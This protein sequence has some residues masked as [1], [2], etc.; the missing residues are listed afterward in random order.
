MIP[1]LGLLG[2]ALCLQVPAPGADAD[3]SEALRSEYRGLLAQESS[4]LDALAERLKGEGQTE[5]AAEVRAQIEPPPPSEG[6]QRFQPLPEV[7][8][9]SGRGLA[10]V[11]S[12]PQAAEARSLRSGTAKALFDLARRAAED[13]QYALAGDCLRGVIAREPDHP[14]ARRLLGYVRTQ[15][16]WATPH[17]VQMLKQG[18]VLH[19]DFG[20]VSADW[21]PHLNRGELPGLVI[22]GRVREWLPAEEANARRSSW[23]PPWQISTAPHFEIQTNVPL[24]EGV[25]FG[26]RLEALY[27]LFFALFAD[28]IGR[29]NLPLARRFDGASPEATRPIK[30]HQVWYFASKEEY[31]AF[32]R[33]VLHRDEHLSL[34]YYMPSREAA[35]LRRPPRSY[36]YRDLQHPGDVMAT[37]FHEAS[38]QLLF[39]SAGPSTFESNAGNYWVWE[40]LGTYFEAVAPQ[41]DGT[42]SYGS[43]E[44]TEFVRKR[45]G[46]LGRESILPVRSLVALSKARFH[47]QP[48][49]YRNY[50]EALALTIFL[51]HYD[52]GRYRKGFLDYVE[53]A[54]HGRL[55]P[56]SSRSLK[57]RLNISSY[58]ELDRQFLDFL[59]RGMKPA[60]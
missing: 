23:N 11:P 22:G 1:A 28:V 18:R 3:R 24:A 20:W 17:A 34:G 48:D 16:G 44:G 52:G 6:P 43:L 26:R 7:I 56:G 41:P 15:D 30:K 51:M 25:A 37:L 40:G 57:S 31:V 54:Y 60:T 19:P 55:R 35:P 12:A 2:L 53:D 50:A 27:D 39:E 38:H 10:N 45:I 29:K 14:E 4:R 36:F 32:F 49:V 21:V 47:E 46:V 58:E 5:A 59:K 33:D 42:L 9:T 8:S 13:E